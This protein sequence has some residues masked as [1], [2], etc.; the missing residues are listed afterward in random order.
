MAQAESTATTTG[1]AATVVTATQRN[2]RPRLALMAYG[3]L[4]ALAV[5]GALGMAPGLPSWYLEAFTLGSMVH[6]LGW[7]VVREVWK[8]KGEA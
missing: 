5:L 3:F 1:T 6:V 7:D 8:R 2:T 4:G